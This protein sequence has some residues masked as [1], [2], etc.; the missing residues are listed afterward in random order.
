[1]NNKFLKKNIFLLVVLSVTIICT[2][3][4]LFMINSEY[5]EMNKYIAETTAMVDQVNK[6]NSQKPAPVQENFERMKLDITGYKQKLEDIRKYI[7]MPYY[8]ASMGFVKELLAGYKNDQGKE[9]SDQEKL[10]RFKS[11]LH[12]YWDENKATV[13]RDQVF[14]SFKLKSKELL[15]VDFADYNIRWDKAMK[16]FEDEAKKHTNEKLDENIQDFFMFAFG[17]SR[18]MSFQTGKY[19]NFARLRRYSLIDYF[20][21]KKVAFAEQGASAFGFPTNERS[22]IDRMNIP[23]YV[24]CWEVVSDIAKRIADS[25][26]LQL[27]EF[28]KNNVEPTVEGNYKFYRFTFKVGGRLE[29]IR[30]LLN[31]LYDAYLDRRI[32]IVRN[33]SLRLEEDTLKS[34]IQQEDAAKIPDVVTGLGDS[35]KPENQVPQE[36]PPGAEAPLP[37]TVDAKTP[38]ISAEEYKNLPY[39]ERP[40]YGKIIFGGSQSLCVATFTVDYV[41]YSTEEMR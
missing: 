9:L 5:A 7:G 13:A 30:N 38:A 34:F 29:S 2:V 37:G 17:F 20:T 1:M 15:G 22:R 28:K 8:D 25:K 32:Y 41:V 12:R 31:N 26:I 14:I 35:A 24:F 36:F 16:K 10:E 21:K 19:D 27:Y 4:M 40:G 6:L 33:I 39:Y 23:K 11:A 3:L 18:N